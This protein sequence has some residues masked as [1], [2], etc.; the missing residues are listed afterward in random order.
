MAKSP[1]YIRDAAAA[2]AWTFK[3]I[4]EYGGDPSQIY[5][6]GHSAGG[7]LSLM[8]A[9]DKSWLAAEN[10]DADKLAAYYPISGQ[11]ATHFTIR[12]E[13]GISFTTPV[14][15]KMAP[16]GNVRKLGTKLLLFTGER[17]LEMM[18]R[19]EENLYLKA[20]LEG[21]G[22]AEIPVYEFKGANH[23][24]VLNP[25]FKAILEDMGE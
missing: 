14:V 16:L 12:T 10:I 5:V 4:A 1:A 20:V 13:R 25:A 2:V 18:A 11:T 15:D 22:N 9:L 21:V 19:Y 3:H 6:S 8:L 7:Y 23:G 24:T 17:S